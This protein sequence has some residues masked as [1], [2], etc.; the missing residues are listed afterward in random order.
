MASP[1]KAPC[2]YDLIGLQA[3]PDSFLE[4]TLMTTKE[5][6]EAAIKSLQTNKENYQ[7]VIIKDLRLGIMSVIRL[8]GVEE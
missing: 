8:D 4:K 6:R 1:E 7:K 2:R 3:P 5:C